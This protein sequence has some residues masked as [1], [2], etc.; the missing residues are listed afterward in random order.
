MLFKQK[1]CQHGRME[2]YKRRLV[3]QGFR[4][5][6]GVHY[7]E[8]FSPTPAQASIRMV[9]GIIATQGWEAR[10]LDVDTTYLIGYLIGYLIAYLIA[11]L[12]G[13]LIGYRRPP[14][15]LG[16]GMGMGI[17]S[18][19]VQKF[20]VKLKA[21]LFDRFQAGLCVFKR[22]LH[23]KI[24]AIIMVYVDDLLVASETKRDEE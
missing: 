20:G 21:K 16:M 15:K 7:A 3:A 13:Y 24:V 22:V 12:I 2:K 10:Q 4:Q 1:L 18:A 14:A 23:G 5:V 11:Y 6:K 19:L 9:F 8:S 17:R